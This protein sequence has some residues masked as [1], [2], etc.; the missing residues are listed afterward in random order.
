MKN[1]KDWIEKT[2]REE[3]RLVPYSSYDKNTLIKVVVAYPDEYKNGLPNLGHQVIY[4]EIQKNKNVFVDRVYLPKKDYIKSLENKK[5]PL[6]S[7]EKFIPL[8]EF[9]AILFSISFESLYI[10]ILQLLKLAKIPLFSIQR[11]ENNPIVIG[12]GHCATYNPEPLSDFFDGFIIGDGEE[13]IHNIIQDLIYRKLNNLNKENL[14]RK[15]ARLNGIY[16]PSFYY[17]EYGKDGSLKNWNKKFID[18][19]TKINRIF[20]S[21]INRNPASSVFLTKN[22]IYQKLVFSLEV[23]RGCKMNCRFCMMAHILRPQRQLTT[24]KIINQIKRGL[25]YNPTF[26]LFFESLSEENME[27]LFNS[28]KPLIKKG[29]KIRLGSLRAEF[30]SDLPIK[31]LSK[32]GQNVLI[33]APESISGRMRNSINKGGIKDQHIFNIIKKASQFGIENF[34]LY[35]LIGLP[36]ENQKIITE[37]ANFISE[38]RLI[39]NRNNMNGILEIHI[40]PIF[41]KPFTPFQWMSMLDQ[42]TAKKNI[43][44]IISILNSRNINVKYNP[45]KDSIIGITEKENEE[46]R[47]TVIIRSVVDSK[48]MFIQPILSRGDRSVGKI[49]YSAFLNGN[50]Y[51]AWKTEIINSDISEQYFKEKPISYIFPWEFINHGISRNYLENEWL[52]AKQGKLSPACF[53]GCVRCELCKKII[54]YD[55]KKCQVKV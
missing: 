27:E 1:I 34:G 44:S 46:L 43:K 11:G 7:W 14:L 18:I 42:E 50:T 49:L 39:M 55:D 16:I 17:P 54:T 47:N 4:K 5:T 35:M 21:D 29:L 6:F 9:D 19:P 22:T 51:K 3:I 13:I 26:K 12:G 23:T 45:I 10:N 52:L 36:N 25:K 38:V 28:I 33:L 32:M 24:N 37:L 40:N 31:L 20:V 30:L 48:L 41:P 53:N 15:L 8:D 2:I